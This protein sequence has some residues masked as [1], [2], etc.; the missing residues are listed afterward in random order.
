M[1]SIFFFYVS[2][3]VISKNVYCCVLKNWILFW[4]YVINICNR[5][6]YVV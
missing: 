6:F 4:Y 5:E 3:V 2:Y 1:Y